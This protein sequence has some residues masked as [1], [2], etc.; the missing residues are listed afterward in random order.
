V[1]SQRGWRRSLQYPDF[2]RRF[3]TIWVNKERTEHNSS[4]IC[5]PLALEW[6]LELL[7]SPLAISWAASG[8]ISNIEGFRRVKK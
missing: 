1:C 5:L 2:K 8:R 4:G 3:G 6:I 7:V